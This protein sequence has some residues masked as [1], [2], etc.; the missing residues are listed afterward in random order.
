MTIKSG[1]PW[2]NKLRVTLA[3]VISFPIYIMP[4]WF[5]LL[6]GNLFAHFWW[7]ILRIRRDVV[8]KNLSLAF[9]DWDQKKKDE[10]AWSS[11]QNLGWGFSEYFK[12]PF[13]NKQN[14]QKWIRFEGE[15]HLQQ[16]L[17]SGKGVCALSLHL[18]NGDFALAGLSL[19]GYPVHL[20][21]KEFSLQWLNNVWF[22][23]RERLGMKF[24]PPRNSGYAV[25]KSL[26]KN[27]LVIFVLDQY[28]GPPIGIKTKFFGAET[29]TA[30]GLSLF[31]MRTG[32]VVLPI[33]TYRETPSKH[34]I[35][36]EAPIEFEDKGNR[37]ETIA[38]MT[39]K[40]SDKI[41][42]L[43]RQRPGQWMWVHRRWKKFP[44]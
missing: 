21:S 31:A 3:R 9:P 29:G 39:Q 20:I 36:I 14:Y 10:I 23:L 24:I 38:H 40:Y 19:K 1:R 34:V 22:A 4:Q 16:A 18:G 5:S 12:L 42:E 26:R 28:A 44:E 11:M 32:S 27:N 7:N 41:E 33:Y 37:E 6:I 13:L 25:V 30:F 17:K 43:V 15:E 35:K 8:Y 2:L